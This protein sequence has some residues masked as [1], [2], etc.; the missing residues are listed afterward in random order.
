MKRSLFSLRPALARGALALLP[1]AALAHDI[2][3]ADR[4][5]MLDGGY[6]QYVGLGA[7]HMLTGDDHLLFLFGVVFFPVPFKRFS[8]AAY[9]GL[10]YA[11]V[12]LLLMPLHGNQHD[13]APNS[14]RFPA[15]E[16]N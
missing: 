13:A 5:R 8:C 9:L 7:S 11:G 6:L 2:S 4:Q 3:E 1:L 15:T 16:H 14:F 10:Q 12:V